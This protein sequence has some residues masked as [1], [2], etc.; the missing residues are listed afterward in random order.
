[1]NELITLNLFIWLLFKRFSSQRPNLIHDTPKAPHITGVGVGLVMKCLVWEWNHYEDGMGHEHVRGKGCP[2]LWCSPLDRDFPSLWSVVIFVLQVTTHTKV[3]YLWGRSEE[4]CG[5]SEGGVW[6]ESGSVWEEWWGVWEEWGRC[7]GGVGKMCGRRGEGVR[8]MEEWGRCVWGVWEEWGRCVGGVRKVC[9][10]SGE[11][12]WEEW[13]RC[14][15]YG[16][17]R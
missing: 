16:G 15:M 2:D 12:V 17:V 14:E 13:G 7:V 9:E 6:E 4:V 1:M 3:C 5:R 8:C 11:G 10:R